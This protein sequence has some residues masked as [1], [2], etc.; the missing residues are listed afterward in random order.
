MRLLA[1]SLL[2]L[3][4]CS[5]CGKK[6]E[7]K[8]PPPPK[9][10]VK[11]TYAKRVPYLIR[12][13]GNTEPYFTINIMPQVSGELTSALFVEGSRVEAGTLLY[14]IDARPYEAALN[15]AIGQLEQ[16]K[17]SLAFNEQRVWRY[18]NLLPEDYVSKLDFEQYLSDTGIAAGKLEQYVGA[19]EKAEVDLGYCWITA[20]ITGRTGEWLVDPGNIVYPEEKTPLVVINQISPIYVTFTIP[21]RQLALV[22][23][24]QSPGGLLVQASLP[25]DPG[26]TFEGRLDLI[27]NTADP[28]T[29]TIMLRAVFANE[30]EEMWPG[31]FVD[32]SIILY[33]IPH[34]I[35]APIDAIQQDEKGH[36]VYVVDENEV[37][38]LI[39]VTLGQRL[40]DVQVIE[41]GLKENQQ[42]VTKGQIAVHAGSKVRIA[43]E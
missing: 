20:P 30:E 32:V 36:F 40:G 33:E 8:T 27:N 34:A 16:A 18:K 41:K 14:T 37:A 2:L 4:L 6:E 9:V 22:Q 31:Q 43:E 28:K 15:E 7:P 17:S 12:G 24:Y 10:I 1:S 35:L 39:R 5:S 13:I 11:K 21:D 25:S 23:K 19:V 3:F 29:G 42:V 38:H 26:Q